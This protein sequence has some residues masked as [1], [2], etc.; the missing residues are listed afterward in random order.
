[1]LVS[2]YYTRT[3]ALVS[4]FDV[5]KV[6]QSLRMRIGLTLGYGFGHVSAGWWAHRNDPTLM[7]FMRYEIC[8]ATLKALIRSHPLRFA[9]LIATTNAWRRVLERSSV[10]MKQYRH[11]IDP[12]RMSKIS[13]RRHRSL[14]VSFLR[15]GTVGDW[16]RILLHNNGSASIKDTERR[17][18][19]LGINSAAGGRWTGWVDDGN[20]VQKRVLS[21]RG[22]DA[23]RA[24]FCVLSPV[25]PL[26]YVLLHAPS[27]FNVY[28]TAY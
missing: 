6:L 2:H 23:R 22:T 19:P 21:W 27:V 8:N 28:C 3:S 9:T 13:A 25:H 10:L 7:L 14:S 12:S 18:A 20:I 4:T 11:K 5:R 24:F 17:L 16:R 26:T 1:M 15:K